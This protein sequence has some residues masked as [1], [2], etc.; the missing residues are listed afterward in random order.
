MT[1]LIQ[2]RLHETVNRNNSEHM[3]FIHSILVF[4]LLSSI[5]MPIS[6]FG[7]DNPC[8]IVRADLD[9]KH[10]RLTEY[11]NTA[12][13]LDDRDDS[14]IITAIHSKIAEFRQQVARLEKE[15]QE[16]EDRKAVRGP[17]GL[18]SAQSDDG[19]DA[20]KTCG[21]L[22]KRLVVLVKNMHYLRRRQS[23]LL[24]QLT[25]AETKELQETATELKAIREALRNRCSVP[26][27]S[28]EF[29]RG[30]KTPN[31]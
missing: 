25:A 28:K 7:Q 22:R 2:K 20:T 1:F 23:S 10:L 8:E 21:E 5:M 16:C 12:K 19:E 24:S 31:N 18:S 27:N 14:E 15:L 17:D 6:C 3:I 11:L 30:H 9:Q 26:T 29:H 13:K 4:S